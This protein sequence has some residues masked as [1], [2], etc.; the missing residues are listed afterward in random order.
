[1]NELMD[2]EARENFN[3]FQ[4]RHELTSNR[5]EQ[6]LAGCQRVIE[7]AHK[8]V[9]E[10][11]RLGWELKKLK[12]AGDWMEVINPKDGMTF[13]YSSFEA[14][15]NYAFGL[16]KTR[17]SDLLRIAQFVDVDEYGSVV[18]KD[19]RYKEMNTSQLIELAPL[20]PWKQCYFTADISVANMRM[21]KRYMDSGEFWEEKDKPDFDLV[22]AAQRWTDNLERLKEESAAQAITDALHK[23]AQ[24]EF[25][26]DRLKIPTSELTEK[27]D[28]DFLEDQ[29]WIPTWDWTK[30]NQTSELSTGCSFATFAGVRSFLAGFETWEQ[31]ISENAFFDKIYRYRFKNGIELY[32]A[33][34]A[35]SIS[36]VD[37]TQKTLIY[38]F[39][40]LGAGIAPIKVA[41]R[42]LEIWMR[43]NEAVLL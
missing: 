32:A 15:S 10:M 14:F 41:K 40:S 9:Q 5:Q 35:N 1:M 37:E 2:Y 16:G 27:D 3:F 7:S 25:P 29:T 36:L 18:Y 39:L 21:C 11:L 24:G 33:T 42:K 8:T 12:D 38:F 34:C 4:Y 43:D 20:G 17:T 30:E 31:V 22:S 13:L 26:A 19:V 6:F 23:A 28:P